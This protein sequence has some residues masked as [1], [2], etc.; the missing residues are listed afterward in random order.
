MHTDEAE[1]LSLKYH[2]LK[3]IAERVLV[4]HGVVCDTTEY[5]VLAAPCLS[6]PTISK[7]P[8]LLLS[9]VL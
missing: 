3:A 8:T 1:A 6:L 4:S 2:H 9:L 5:F 7:P